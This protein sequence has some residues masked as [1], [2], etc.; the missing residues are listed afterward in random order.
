MSIPLEREAQPYM[1]FLIAIVIGVVVGAIGGF[2]IRDRQSNAI[3]LGP[4]LAAAGALL[5]SVLA[6]A[7]GKPGYGAKEAILQVVLAI[8]GVG[9][10]V[11][12]ALRRSAGQPA[13]TND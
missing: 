8:V 3:W 7:L 4:L 5:A 10:L 6:T 13:H 9:V 2:V 11:A 12:L 1:N